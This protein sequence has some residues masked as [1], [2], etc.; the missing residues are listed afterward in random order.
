MGVKPRPETVWL[1]P[2][3]PLPRPSA[4][5]ARVANEERETRNEKR[6][7]VPSMTKP[8]GVVDYPV[9]NGGHRGL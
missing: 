1:T 3:P 9:G 4:G 2:D 8:G 7:M 6:G 5:G